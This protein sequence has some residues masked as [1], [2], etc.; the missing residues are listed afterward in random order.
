MESLY[1][2]S[3]QYDQPPENQQLFF[4]IKNAVLGDTVTVKDKTTLVLI[5]GIS[6]IT[7]PVLITDNEKVYISPK[8]NLVEVQQGGKYR[9]TSKKSKKTKM[10]K[11]SAKLGKRSTMRTNKK[12]SKNV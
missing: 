3:P 10:M 5:S 11:K 8:E 1:S 7:D 9:K 4:V 6:E 12:Y 2:P